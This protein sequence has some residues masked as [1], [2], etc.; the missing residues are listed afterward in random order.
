MQVVIHLTSLDAVLQVWCLCLAPA[1]GENGI[2][3]ITPAGLQ[4]NIFIYIAIERY[5]SYFLKSSLMFF[6]GSKFT[7]EDFRAKFNTEL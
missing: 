5:I 1:R 7:A 3:T 6:R 2:L 4:N